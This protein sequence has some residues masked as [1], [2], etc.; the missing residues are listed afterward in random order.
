MALRFRRVFGLLLILVEAVGFAGGV[1][2]CSLTPRVAGREPWFA[3]EPDLRK[4]AGQLTASTWTCVDPAGLLLYAAHEPLSERDRYLRSHDL[5]DVPAWQ[6]YLL[7]ALAF[8]EAVSG[9]D[10]DAEIRRLATGLLLFYEATGV[11]GVL[12]RSMIADYRGP[13]LSWMVTEE[14]HPGASWQ[15]GPTGIWW[16]NGLAKA[17]LMLAGFGCAMPLVLDQRGDL[18]LTDETRRVLLAVLL[19]AVRRLVEADFR[20]RDG[21]GSFTEYGNL[22][23]QALNGFNMVGTLSLLRSA[24]AYDRDLRRIYEE[25]ITAWGPRIGVSLAALGRAVA[26]AGHRTLGKPSYS[27]LQAL[28]L[29]A[30]CLR[31]QE[32]RRE[33]VRHLHHGLHGLW[34]FVRHE[35][36]VPFTLCYAAY[37]RPARAEAALADA[38]QD[39]RDFPLEKREWHGDRVRTGSI[40]PLAN[41][42][43]NSCYW[44]SSPYLRHE[45]EQGAPTRVRYAAMDF[46][47]AY[48]MGRYFGLV[49]DE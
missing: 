6:G 2:G 39:L 47:L 33:H 21:D 11:K 10:R 12:G 44:K 27:D 35:R 13:R 41:R 31:M 43:V 36:N 14:T 30:L 29:S 37:V 28:A 49:P 42:P 32:S 48:W 45:P 16:R 15:Q 25:K 38:I 26:L 18:H 46:L 17:N 24:G 3:T 8:E 5:A 19:P 23:P 7:A 40:Q 20:M 4:K 1:G 9:R 34:S 22:G